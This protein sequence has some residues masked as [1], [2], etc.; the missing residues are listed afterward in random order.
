MKIKK[1]LFIV[2]EGIDGSGKTTISKML[3]AFFEEN[4]NKA[5]WFREPGDSAWGKKIRELA[6]LEDSIPIEEELQYFIEDRKINVRENIL[7]SLEAG[8]I[9]IVDRYYYS[10]ACYQGARGLD[11]H[12]IIR[13]NREFAPVPDL[14]FLIDVDV[15]TAL[16]RIRRGRDIE[17]K[18]FEK[19]EYLQQVREN[20]LGL[21][22]LPYFRVIDGTAE[23]EQ[24]FGWVKT[25]F[26]EQMG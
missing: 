20:Y 23:V 15:D 22:D 14:V 3:L 19:K 12:E 10:S 17:A 13:L 5:A 18:L 4:G 2:F 21:R 16:E 6:N 7:P 11:L 24:V 8:K 9:V 1:P 26:L 25:A